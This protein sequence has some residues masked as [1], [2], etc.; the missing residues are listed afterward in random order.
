MSLLL[1]KITPTRRRFLGGAAMMMSASQTRPGLLR[2]I[3]HRL[4]GE[5]ASLPDEGGL[6]SF[7]G[8]TGWLNSAPLTPEGLRGRVVLVDFWTYTCINWI[9]TLPYVRA[10]AAKYADAGL[11]VVGVHTP[12]FGFEQDVANITRE[13]GNFG[14][15]YPIAID[16]TYA[17]WTAFDNH[18][19]PAV[20]LADAEGRIRFHHFGEGEYEMTEM[21][22]QQLLIEAGATDVDQG[23]VTVA[24]RGLEV[25]ADWGTLG[26]PET[27]TGYR[28]SSGFAQDRDAQYDEPFVY[29]APGNLSLND[30]GLSGTWTVTEH[31]AV[32]N[33]PG[34]RVAFQFQARDLNL[35]M[36]PAT[37]RTSIPFRVFLDGQPAEGA[38]GTDVSAEGSGTV[39]EQRTY[40]LIRQTGPIDFRRFEIEFGAAGVEAYCF[41]FG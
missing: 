7:A 35:V 12:E 38:S 13:A 6:A 25:A 32:A 28:Q 29:D 39:A 34:A 3:V 20:Y 22:I 5:R 17:V 16:S 9:R 15:T 33:A 36:G 40:Q 8:A 24:P 23:L 14:V 10:W 21:A 37:P 18:Y 30:W 31:A 11:T 1:P 26:S 4:A 2:S 27:Y 41:T 19:W